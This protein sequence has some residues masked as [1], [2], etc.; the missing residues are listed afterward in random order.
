MSDVGDSFEIEEWLQE[1]LGKGDYLYEANN[2]SLCVLKQLMCI[3][4]ISKKNDALRLSDLNDKILEYRQEMLYY[5]IATEYL[6]VV[7][8]QLNTSGF[9]NLKTLTTLAQKLFSNQINDNFSDNCYIMA[10]MYLHQKVA[11]LKND[12]IAHKQSLFDLNSSSSGQIDNEQLIETTD[13]L[14][15]RMTSSKLEEEMKMSKYYASKNN[16]YKNRFNQENKK[17][18]QTGVK[19]HLHH[20]HL[21]KTSQE[22]SKLQRLTSTIQ[23]KLSVYEKLPASFNLLNITL[24]EKQAEKASLEEKLNLLFKQVDISEELK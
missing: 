17:L 15:Q 24:A 23:M 18:T 12:C 8:S 5:K 4:K 9:S 3:N 21:R 14:R 2:R 22:V 1:I 10:L 7:P 11:L 20:G 13:C 6:G 19:S 16:S